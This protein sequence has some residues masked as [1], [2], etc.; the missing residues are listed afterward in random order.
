M[1]EWLYVGQYLYNHVTPHTTHCDYFVICLA[2]VDMDL[3]NNPRKHSINKYNALYYN[4][5]KTI[6]MLRMSCSVHSTQMLF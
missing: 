5:G 4:I 3:I 2:C 1:K 6:T